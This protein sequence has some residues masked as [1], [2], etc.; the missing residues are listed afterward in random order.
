MRLSW[1]CCNW[2]K[3][4]YNY[5]CV[6][7]AERVLLLGAYIFGYCR[8]VHPLAVILVWENREGLAA[9]LL[10]PKIFPTYLMVA[11]RIISTKSL[12]PE[13]TF[14]MSLPYW[15]VRDSSVV[16]WR[17]CADFLVG[18]WFCFKMRHCCM[19]PLLWR[20]LLLVCSYL[21]FG[22]QVNGKRRLH[23]EMCAC[24]SETLIIANQWK[25]YFEAKWKISHYIY[26]HVQKAL[27]AREIYSWYTSVILFFWNA[28]KTQTLPR[29]SSKNLVLHH[30]GISLWFF[31]D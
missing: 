30:F 20:T 9:G 8:W 2:L 25:K 3:S 27:N 16:T 1:N 11:K 28:C 4:Y 24:F 17:W 12:F 22:L 15:K 18:F 26:L 5:L 7:V 21:C 10:M 23:L 19:V 29:K 6:V 31:K 13:I 14:Q